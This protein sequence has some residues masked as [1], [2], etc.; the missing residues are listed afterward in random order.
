MFQVGIICI[1]KKNNDYRRL[2]ELDEWDKKSGATHRIA[3]SNPPY[4]RDKA[5]GVV[6]NNIK[7]HTFLVKQISK[8]TFVLMDDEENWSN[9]K[10]YFNSI[11]LFKDIIPIGM[12]TETK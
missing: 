7:H 11:E 4:F 5:T 9:N 8:S 10:L 1:N 12:I 6:T 2:I 3:N